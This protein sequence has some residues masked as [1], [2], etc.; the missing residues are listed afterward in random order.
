VSAPTHSLEQTA[1]PLSK[2]D[3]SNDVLRSRPAGGSHIGIAEKRSA[4][5]GVVGGEIGATRNM[6]ATIIK[7]DGIMR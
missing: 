6:G 2:P 4:P 7:R 5:I 1:T 3:G